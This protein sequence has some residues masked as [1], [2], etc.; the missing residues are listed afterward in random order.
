MDH[1]D[2]ASFVTL[3]LLCNITQ[4]EER[5]EH[6]HDQLELIRHERV[7]GDEVLLGLV[8]VVCG[9]QFELKV[10]RCLGA[11]VKVA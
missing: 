11:V 7:V 1:L 4:I 3:H 8:A 10:K 9:R 2:D 6:L 5:V